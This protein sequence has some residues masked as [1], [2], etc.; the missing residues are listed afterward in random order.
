MDNKIKQK[1]LSIIERKLRALNYLLLNFKGSVCAVYSRIVGY[2]RDTANWNEGK[3]QEFDERK[4][5]TKPTE[6]VLEEKKKGITLIK[7]N[8]IA[9]KYDY[10]LVENEYKLQEKIK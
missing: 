9:T 4:T 1:Q 3:R 6:E 5:F 10:I 8:K 2:Y 7:A